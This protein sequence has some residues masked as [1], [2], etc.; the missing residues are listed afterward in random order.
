MTYRTTKQRQAILAIL[1]GTKTYPNAEWIYNRLKYEIPRL[2]MGT[3]YRNLNV[4]M[5]QGYIQKLS[6]MGVKTS[7]SRFD[8]C[9][10]IHY[11]ISCKCCDTVEDLELPRNVSTVLQNAASTI[12]FIVTGY[13]VGVTGT[14]S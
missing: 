12:G 14:M 7:H 2:S 13:H 4:L 5:K 10:V 1:K 8:A 9:T 3:V 11:H 6:P